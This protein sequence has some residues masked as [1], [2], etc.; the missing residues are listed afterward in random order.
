MEYSIHVFHH[1]VCG[2]VGG[3]MRV[4][5]FTSLTVNFFYSPSKPLEGRPVTPFTLVLGL[6]DRGSGWE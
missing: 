3:W 1:K 6:K 5:M 4:Q 2:W